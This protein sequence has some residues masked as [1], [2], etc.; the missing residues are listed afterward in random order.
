ME[1]SITSA[2]SQDSNNEHVGETQVPLEN[3][4]TKSSDGNC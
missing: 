4:N 1:Q 2:G 3:T